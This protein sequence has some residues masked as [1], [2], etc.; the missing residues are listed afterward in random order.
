MFDC[1]GDDVGLVHLPPPVGIGDVAA[2]EHGLFR[3][4]AM[5]D[6]EPGGKVNVLAEV[7]VLGNRLESMT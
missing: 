2:L 1:Y 7:D 4:V 6:L 3:V 5:V